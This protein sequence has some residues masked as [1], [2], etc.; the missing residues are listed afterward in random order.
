M[1]AGENPANV[2]EETALPNDLLPAPR[3]LACRVAFLKPAARFPS[4]CHLDSTYKDYICICYDAGVSKTPNSGLNQT[5][6]TTLT[7]KL[8]RKQSKVFLV[9][10]AHFPTLLLFPSTSCGPFL[11]FTPKCPFQ[12][13]ATKKR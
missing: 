8:P 6:V 3:L 12:P 9:F 7:N 4:K 5:G 10:R 2:S 11:V 13:V 1:S